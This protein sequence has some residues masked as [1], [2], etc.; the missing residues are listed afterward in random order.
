MQQTKQP[1]PRRGRRR[2]LTCSPFAT[3]GYPRSVAFSATCGPLRSLRKLDRETT[4]F[5][6]FDQVWLTFAD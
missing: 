1:A 2:E 3:G 5:R 4:R 6:S